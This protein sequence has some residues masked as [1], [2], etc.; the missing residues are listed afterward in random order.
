MIIVSKDHN[1]VYN[2]NVAERIY[3]ASDR[4]AVKI[5]AGSTRAGNLGEYG[6]FEKAKKALEIV[7]T[8]IS[9]GKKEVVWM[10][11]DAMVQAKMNENKEYYHHAT[12]KKT[13]GHGGS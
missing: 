2:W 9:I 8:E 7:M 3:I 11:D 1:E 12:G 6:S 4:A 5:V 10:P 13:K